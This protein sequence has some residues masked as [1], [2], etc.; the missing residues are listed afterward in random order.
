MSSH[1]QA[2]GFSLIEVLVTVVILSLGLLGIA[3]MQLSAKRSSFE[4]V[5]R[6][7]AVLIASHIMENIRANNAAAASYHTGATNPLGGGTLGANPPACPPPCTGAA[8]ANLDR[9][10]WERMLDGNAV[11]VNGVTNNALVNARGCIVFAPASPDRPNT[12]EVLVILNW[13]GLE[14]NS[15]PI[16]WADNTQPRCDTNPA[17]SNSNNPRGQQ[18]VLTSY[19]TAREDL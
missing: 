14:N 18:L 16:D 5:Q 4:A 11:I 15:P 3:A 10:N 7:Q 8:R 9:W 2:G 12:G 6:S 17:T 19:I 13:L 1:R